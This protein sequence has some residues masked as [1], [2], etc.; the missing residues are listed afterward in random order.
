MDNY[1]IHYRGEMFTKYD[2]WRQG[3]R[4]LFIVISLSKQII[5]ENNKN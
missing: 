5:T 4:G 1:Y 3:R 2:P